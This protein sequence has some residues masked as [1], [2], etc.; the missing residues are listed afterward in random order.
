MLPYAWLSQTKVP[1][2]AN[3]V[4][5]AYKLLSLAQ[6]RQAYQSAQRLALLDEGQQLY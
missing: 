4:T 5:T 1:L 3:M 6:Q 2:H